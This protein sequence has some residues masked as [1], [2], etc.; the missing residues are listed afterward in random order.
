MIDAVHDSIVNDARV[1]I[2]GPAWQSTVQLVK[3]QVI[4]WYLARKHE[5]HRLIVDV[6][7]KLFGVP[8]ISR[9]L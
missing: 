1:S 7:Y 5:E 3:Q 2:R 8:T 4:E 6:T 9:S